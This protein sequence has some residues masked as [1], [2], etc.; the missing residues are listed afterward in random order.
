MAIPVTSDYPKDAR[1]PG[2]GW[3]P[4]IREELQHL[5]KYLLLKSDDGWAAPQVA[6]ALDVLPCTDQQPC[7]A[8]EGLERALRDRRQANRY[9]G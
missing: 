3:S 5:S 8:G 6:E 7:F 9:L 2:A 1:Y 4:P